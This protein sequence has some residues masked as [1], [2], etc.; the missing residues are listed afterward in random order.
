MQVVPI[1]DT[2]AQTLSVT[3]ANQAVTLAIYQKSTGLFCD[4]SVS[5][6][7]ILT[8]VICQNLNRIV[9]DLYLGFVGDLIF[10][11]LQ[12]TSDPSAPGLGTRFVLCYLELS[13][14]NGA[15]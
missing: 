9:R 3:L 5:G 7:T 2:Y 8:G 1:A 11:D 14:L 4:V 6:S 15:G 10:V 13:D 12:G